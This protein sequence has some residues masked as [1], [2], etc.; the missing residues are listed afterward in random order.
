MLV[1]LVLLILIAELVRDALI[2]ADSEHHRLHSV[3]VRCFRLFRE[4]AD[5]GGPRGGEEGALQLDV[6]IIVQSL[7]RAG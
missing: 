4:V 5:E 3:R 7:A 6:D 1:V 2:R